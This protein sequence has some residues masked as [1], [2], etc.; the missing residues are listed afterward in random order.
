MN[1]VIVT[2]GLWRADN[3]PMSIASS[4]YLM[5]KSISDSPERKHLPKGLTHPAFEDPREV[6]E[7]G[8]QY[9]AWDLQMLKILAAR[10][11]DFPYEEFPFIKPPAAPE[12]N[13]VL[14]VRY[15][16]IRDFACTDD[17]MYYRVQHEVLSRPWHVQ[18]LRS[19]KTRIDHDLL[20][21][22]NN[23]MFGAR[24]NEINNLTL[25]TKVKKREGPVGLLVSCNGELYD[26]S[27]G[28]VRHTESDEVI[29][30]GAYHMIEFD[31]QLYHFKGDSITRTQDQE[32]IQRFPDIKQLFV[33]NQ[34]LHARTPEG[35]FNVHT[36]RPIKLGEVGDV[37]V[38]EDIIYDHRTPDQLYET[39]SDIVAFIS[40]SW[41]IKCFGLGL[42][43][44]FEGVPHSI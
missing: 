22:L 31:G 6:V 9:N 8:P 18:D 21:G 29:G 33:Y 37:I 15:D 19:G 2:G 43:K 10:T 26:V 5:N 24:N 35:L 23:Q 36:G 3:G 20:L 7:I 30:P 42:E 32:E 44:V 25:D 13:E 14:E 27:Q 40:P 11:S 4:V 1:V 34:Q 41:S 16:E 39:L 38:C 17:N 12:E 28:L